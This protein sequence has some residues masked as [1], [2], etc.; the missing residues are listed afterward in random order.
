MAFLV[1][2]G[3][4]WVPEEIETRAREGKDG[5]TIDGDASVEEVRVGRASRA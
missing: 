2:D 3:R 4:R 1:S 5:T